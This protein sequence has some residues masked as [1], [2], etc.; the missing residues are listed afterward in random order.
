MKTYKI[1][2]DI[3]AHN[4]EAHP[5]YRVFVDGNLLTERDFVWNPRKIY[6]SEQIY[7]NLEAGG[8]NLSIEQVSGTPNTID[9]RNVTLDDRPSSF[10]F[11]TT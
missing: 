1:T 3:Y 9:P 2:V 4:F 8:H 7:V 11:T 5:R 10:H 6:I